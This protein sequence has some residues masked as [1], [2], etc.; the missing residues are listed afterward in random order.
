MRGIVAQKEEAG[1]IQAAL[2]ARGTRGLGRPSFDARNQGHAWSLPLGKAH[3]QAW[4]EH[5]YFVGRAQW[6]IIQPPSLKRER[7]SLEESSVTSFDGR[8]RT[9]KGCPS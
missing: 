9:D 2:R 5:L 3:K 6:T 8:S 7:A 1:A 4:K